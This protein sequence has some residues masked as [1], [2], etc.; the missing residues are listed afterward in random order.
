[1]RSFLFQYFYMAKYERPWKTVEEEYGK[2]VK[3]EG[4]SQGTLLELTQEFFRT[5]QAASGENKEID[6]LKIEEHAAFLGAKERRDEAIRKLQD[7]IKA[8]KY[9][10]SITGEF[11]QKIRE[12]FERKSEALDRRS[13]EVIS[14]MHEMMEREKA[15]QEKVGN[16]RDTAIRI[17]K[18]AFLQSSGY[19]R[20]KYVPGEGVLALQ[21]ELSD[22]FLEKA[23]LRALLERIEKSEKADSRKKTTNIQRAIEE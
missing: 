4:G 5:A 22:I 13:A 18:I 12:E 17:F 6:P 14:M 2:R 3:P 8:K 10:W 16:W 19:E 1:M 23:T 15:A 9:H 20:E 11:S 21:K 7:S